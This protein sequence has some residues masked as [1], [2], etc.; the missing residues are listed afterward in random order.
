V[1]GEREIIDRAIDPDGRVVVLTRERWGHILAGHPELAA[2]RPL[3]MRAIGRPDHRAPDLLTTRERYF[4]R[5]V[6]PSRW[7]RVVVDFSEAEAEVVTAFAERR[8][9]S[10]WQTSTR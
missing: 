10:G 3:V 9:P 6:G 2:C 4:L 7:L 1:S 5:G 8:D